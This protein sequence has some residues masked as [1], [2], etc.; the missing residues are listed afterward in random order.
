MGLKPLLQ[1]IVSIDIFGVEIEAEMGAYKIAFLHTK[2][3]NKQ[4]NRQT[5]GRPTT[6]F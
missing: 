2:C 5:D 6:R 3:S 1:P 4:T